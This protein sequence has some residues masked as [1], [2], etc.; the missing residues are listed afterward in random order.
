MHSAFPL[1][2]GGPVH[3]VDQYPQSS[4]TLTEKRETMKQPPYYVTDPWHFLDDTGNLPDDLPGPARKLSL[5]LSQIIEECSA[6]PA[7]E[8]IETSLKCRRRP[9]RKPCPGK[10]LSWRNNEN[11]SIKW[12]CTQCGTGGEIHNW[13]G[14]PWDKSEGELGF[15][16]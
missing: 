8:T 2:V 1:I 4:Y 11:D 7:G 12:M 15:V 6:Q 16:S 3:F 13:R 5:F 14:C 10:I 9:G